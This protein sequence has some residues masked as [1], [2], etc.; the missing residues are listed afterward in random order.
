MSFVSS[1]HASISLSIAAPA[2]NEAEGIQAVVQEWYDYLKNQ[3]DIASFEIVIC[4][5]GSKDT[6][7]FLL[8]ELAKRYPE[9][10]P[11]HFT[12]NQGAAH[13]L[14]NAIQHTQ[15]DWVLLIDSDNQFPIENLSVML[16]ELRESKAKAVLGIRKKKDHFFSRFGSAA[17][18]FVCNKIYGTKIKDF[19]SACKLVSGPLLR[20]FKLEAKGMNYST[21]IT[22]QL[23]ESKSLFKE[24][25]IEH[26]TRSTGKSSLKLLRDSFHRFLFVMYISLRQLLIKL[27][28]LRRPL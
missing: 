7:G 11:V 16:A 15:F 20:S 21:E 26:R 18:G 27:G 23:I 13:A 6:T 4:N 22:A 17:S 3:A 10:R 9:V 5:D 2:F 28:T 24:V 1:D 8:D 14:A 12:S 19:N 25:N